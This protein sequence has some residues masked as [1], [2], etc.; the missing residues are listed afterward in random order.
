METTGYQNC[1]NGYV[2]YGHPMRLSA[3]SEK[4]LRAPPSRF[5]RLSL[6]DRCSVARGRDLATRFSHGGQ[7]RRDCRT[8]RRRRSVGAGYPFPIDGSLRPEAFAAELPPRKR[9]SEMSN[10]RFCTYGA[11]NFHRNR[12][13]CKCTKSCARP[14]RGAARPNPCRALQISFFAS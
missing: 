7:K 14:A 12:R 10:H 1:V 3:H 6:R 8:T 4:P 13:G 11:A 5:R 9:S 2:I